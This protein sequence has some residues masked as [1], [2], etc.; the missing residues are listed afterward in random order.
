MNEREEN[1]MSAT[2]RI[3]LSEMDD[4]F[5][6]TLK[7]RYGNSEIEITIT[8]TQATDPLLDSKLSCKKL[9]NA[10]KSVKKDTTQDKFSWEDLESFYYL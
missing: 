5:I 3:K 1:I 4:N 7:A 6:D 2:Y 10:I 8:E 9:V